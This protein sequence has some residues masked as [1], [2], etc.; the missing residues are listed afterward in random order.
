MRQ[1]ALSDYHILFLEKCDGQKAGSKRK[2]ING[3]S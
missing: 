1:Y 3:I 2:K